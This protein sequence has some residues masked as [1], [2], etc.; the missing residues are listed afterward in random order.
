[1]AACH[2]SPSRH[3]DPTRAG[4]GNPSRTRYDTSRRFWDITR[5]PL[6]SRDAID[7]EISRGGLSGNQF[8]RRLCPNSISRQSDLSPERH[9]MEAIRILEKSTAITWDYDA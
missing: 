6:V 7:Q 4:V 2:A 8:R 3:G 9:A 1:M 5:S